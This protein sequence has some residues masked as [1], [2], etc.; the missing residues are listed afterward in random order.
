[1]LGQTWV[2]G[3]W[4]NVPGATRRV[5]AGSQHRS[6]PRRRGTLMRRS[7]TILPSTRPGKTTRKHQVIRIVYP[8]GT[9]GSGPPV[10]EVRSLD[11]DQV[12]T[13]SADAEVIL[14]AGS[15]H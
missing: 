13:V 2:F 7:G 15:F 1:M 9:V 5:F 8:E 6:T 12:F 14:A 10:V 4:P 3:L 11:N